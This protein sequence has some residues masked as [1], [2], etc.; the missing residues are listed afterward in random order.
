MEQNPLVSIGIP[1]Y[2]RA[3]SLKKAL[4][5]AI[6]QTY[7]NLEIIISDNASTDE[8][9][10][11]CEDYQR[12]DNRIK[13]LRQVENAGSIANFNIVLKEATGKYFMWLADDDWIDLNFIEECLSFLNNHNDYALVSGK[14][15]FYNKKNQFLYDGEVINAES[16]I[17]IN[18]TRKY[19]R[20]VKYNSCFYGLAERKNLVKI[21]VK[22]GLAGDWIQ[23]ANL[24]LFG[25]VKTLEKVY[26]HRSSEGVSTNAS[27][28]F[29]SVGLSE[30][31]AELFN[32]Y[33]FQ[34]II[35]NF[36]TQKGLQ[37]KFYEKILLLLTLFSS[38]KFMAFLKRKLFWKEF[39]KEIFNNIKKFFRLVSYKF[40][41]S[42]I[43]KNKNQKNR[44]AFFTPL[45]PLE[46]GISIYSEDLISILNKTGIFFDIYVD[47]YIPKVKEII[48]KN[49]IYT[50]KNFDSRKYSY[51][52]VIYQLGS[53]EAHHAYMYDA[54]TTSHSVVI[55]NDPVLNLK[56]QSQYILKAKKIIVHSKWAYNYVVEKIP[57]LK[58][59]VFILPQLATCQN[60]KNEAI[61]YFSKKNEK[62]T[63]VIGSFGIVTKNK[64]VYESIKYLEDFLL[65]NNAIYILAGYSIS[66]EI[67]RP[68]INSKDLQNKVFIYENID[69]NHLD[70]LIKKCNIC[71]SLRNPYFGETSA[72]V[73]RILKN[74][75]PAIIS[76]VGAFSEIPDSCVF[77]VK[78]N[79]ENQLK[80]IIDKVFIDNEILIEKSKNSMEYIKNY[81]SEEIVLKKFMDILEINIS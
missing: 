68:Y 31:K 5:S 63:F 27:T 35:K 67:I 25:K 34:N 58:D 44:Y 10:E 64:K 39:I 38:Q 70:F 72:A 79:E 49:S 45:S 26:S 32:F 51:D 71:I 6:N 42:L 13:Y 23:I 61:N 3:E 78:P 41:Y 9:K 53:T 56:K 60:S 57:S 74:G 46:S 65:N 75:I 48:E 40:N 24:C 76:D 33:I 12:K 21:G 19:L 1:T 59:Q 20:K 52:M 80:Y 77:K 8:T 36:Y 2:N 37:L 66:D 55:L 69:L 18:R 54:I 4:D 50:L 16:N 14:A 43:I 62:N 28:L 7:Q 15:K 22:E 81:H 17:R 47:K 73:L 29:K 30:K 11:I